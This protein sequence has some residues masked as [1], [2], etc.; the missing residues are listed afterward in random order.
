MQTLMILLKVYDWAGWNGLPLSKIPEVLETRRMQLV[1]KLVVR[2]KMTTELLQAVIKHQG[3]TVLDMDTSDLSSVET[4]TLVRAVV[5]M[6]DVEL[7][8]SWDMDTSLGKQQ[9]EAIL[10]G[11]TGEKSKLKKLNLSELD[12]S[13]VSPCLLANA[14][15][16]LEEICLWESNLN[17]KQVEAL[18]TSISSENLRLKKLDLQTNDLSS[19]EPGL[20]AKAVGRLSEVRLRD[21]QMNKHQIEKILISI[22]ERDSNLYNLDLTYV[23]LNSVETDLLARSINLLEEAALGNENSF[24]DEMHLAKVQAEAILTQS[25]LQT[26]L[27]KLTI[28]CPKRLDENL[29]AKAGQAIRELACNTMV[30]TSDYVTTDTDGNDTESDIDI[31]A[32]DSS[33]DEI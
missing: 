6:V 7:S 21:T 11:I 3:L 10:I 12:V 25:L 2:G 23:N 32:S 33:Q 5:S 15:I 8:G 27:K 22:C 4:D 17:K 20:L 14:V 31:D 16:L 29:V 1:R 30:H 13:P 26:S 18:I 9:L 28:D 24:A 19:V